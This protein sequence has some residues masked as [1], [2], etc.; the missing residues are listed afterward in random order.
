MVEIPIPTP[1]INLKNANVI[2]SD[3]IAEPIADIE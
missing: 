2:G 3:E 1:P